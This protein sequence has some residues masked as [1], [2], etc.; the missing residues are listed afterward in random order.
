MRCGLSGWL[1]AGSIALCGCASAPQGATAGGGS[2]GSWV[3]RDLAPYLSDELANNPRFA[4]AS[5]RFVALDGEEISPTI[6]VLLDDVRDELFNELISVSG[7]DLAW[8]PTARPAQHH[9]TLSQMD[10]GRRRQATHYI[11]LDLSEAIGGQTRLK[12][13]ALDLQERQWVS[14]FGLRWSGRLNGA[15]AE[16]AADRRV[17]PTLRGLRPLPFSADQADLATGYLAHNL[18]C[19]LQ[20]GAPKRLALYL[21]EP[22]AD[23]PEFFHTV[24]A[25]IG[26]SMNRFREVE[27]VDSIEAADA[28]VDSEMV[29]INADLWQVWLGVTYRLDGR[30]LSGADTPAYVALDEAAVARVRPP[31]RPVASAPSD[32][33]GSAEAMPPVGTPASVRIAEFATWVPALGGPCDSRS[34]WA[35][36]ERRAD[37]D[38]RFDRGD[39]FALQ[40]SVTGSAA[41]LVTRAGEG[42]WY[43]LGPSSCATTDLGR[44]A[45]GLSDLRFPATGAMELTGTGESE[46][47]YLIATDNAE[48][49]RR[50]SAIVSRLPDG[51]RDG[52]GEP[53]SP[54]GALMRAATERD[55]RILW[56]R[57][58]VKRRS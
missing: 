12:V 55:G 34:P 57:L 22:P 28:V 16:A 29:R 36:G 30:Q 24:M 27:L 18:S 35:Q 38:E 21:Q 8:R 49:A 15:Q 44:G 11:G 52:V 4:G 26:R 46:S 58:D 17:D 50:V 54:L 45:Q 32:P 9:R 51:C 2:L 39:C 56:R 31:T 41:F 33:S 13:R 10:C 53:R 42:G 1:L 6:D 23:R 5:L 43:R 40:A 48:A 25:I 20:E 3:E 47:Y 14:G 37:A 7:V 19:L